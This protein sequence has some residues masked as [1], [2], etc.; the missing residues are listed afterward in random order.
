M[1]PAG[2]VIFEAED[3]GAV[4]QIMEGDPAVR[5]GVFMARLNSFKL[6]FG[7][8]GILLLDSGS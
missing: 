8:P 7:W 2:I 6:S 1:S 3:L 4:Q 5:S